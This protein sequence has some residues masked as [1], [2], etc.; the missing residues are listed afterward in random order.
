MWGRARTV[1]RDVS[2]EAVERPR[3]SA[4]CKECLR[5]AWLLGELSAVLD[6][7]CRADGRLFELLALDDGELIQAVGGRR[8]AE[9]A[10]GY[11]S[12]R[13]DRHARTGRL[14]ELCMHDARYPRELRS[15]GICPLLHVAGGVE[16]LRELTDRPVVAL[17]GTRA[18]SDYGLAIASDLARGLAAS[19]VTV[20]APQVGGIAAAALSGALASRGAT[21][22][23]AGSGPDLAP[24]A[25]RRS[26]RAALSSGGCALSELSWGVN[27]R[28]WGIASAE[29][30]LA[31][32]ANTML[33]VEARESSR[34]LSAA[35]FAKSLG[36]PVAAIPGHV[37]APASG[38][39][40]ALLR[41]GAQLVRD[42]ADVLELLYEAGHTASGPKQDETP[43]AELEPRLRS[44]LERVG[45]GADTPGKLAGERVDVGEVLRALSELELLGLL[46]RGDGGRYV[47]RVSVRS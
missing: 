41:D 19:G 7:N 47:V 11:A 18:A 21:L 22:T 13:A 45:A 36:R 23:I 38:G 6:L 29:R 25:R 40:H 15:A 43:P 17:V 35:R 10:R 26:L 20:A 34:E 33:V 4:A 46:S 27:G 5:R 39:C 1:R 37:T 32:L 16:R 28:R 2:R 24:E 42:A 9:L 44:V 8:R 12:F 14:V 30:T 31:A 3:T